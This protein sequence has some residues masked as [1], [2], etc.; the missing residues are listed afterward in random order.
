MWTLKDNR[1]TILTSRMASCIFRSAW[2]Q[3][4]ASQLTENTLGCLKKKRFCNHG[5]LLDDFPELSDVVSGAF[6]GGMAI[7]L[8]ELPW[9]LG[10]V[11]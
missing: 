2:W 4:I 11:M 9:L 1:K 8:A 5:I 6:S 10:G 3:S 7:S